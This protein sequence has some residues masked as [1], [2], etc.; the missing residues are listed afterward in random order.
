MAF[1]PIARGLAARANLMA[2]PHPARPRIAL[3]GDSRV[4]NAHLT[5]G[6]NTSV[7]HYGLA[8]HVTMQTGGRV[9]IPQR[10]NFGVGGITCEDIVTRSFAHIAAN[11]PAIYAGCHP[12]PLANTPGLTPLEACA[13]SDADLVMYLAS[14]NDRAS[15]IPL[16]TSQAAVTTSLTRLRQAGK[17]VIVVAEMPRGDVANTARRLSGTQLAFQMRMAQWLRTLRMP[18]V[19]VVDAWPALALASSATGDAQAGALYDGLH[20]GFSGAWLL[21]GQIAAV[22]NTRYPPFNL[23]PAS[24]SDVWSADNPSGSLIAN[25]TLGNIGVTPAAQSGVT[26]TGQLPTHWQ[27]AASA[28]MSGM[29]IAYG[30]AVVGGVGHLAVTLSGTPTGP[31]PTLLLRQTIPAGPL[32]GIAVGDVVQTA[33][34]AH[35]EAGALGYASLLLLQRFYQNNNSTVI[36][37]RRGGSYAQAGSAFTTIPGAASGAWGGPFVTEPWTVSDAALG[38][39]SQALWQIDFTQNVAVGATILIGPTAMRKV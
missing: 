24:A 9:D 33:G 26:I 8:F 22:I 10:L 38:N 28:G 34:Q 37:E 16:A 18:G 6:V 17:P 13:Q 4:W 21:G 12:Q 23:L 31:S 32:A 30:T 5:A 25:P 20:Q 14:T 39:N 15:G 7:S 27:H 19:T 35:V 29:T 3:L 11:T 1:D 2:A 36:D